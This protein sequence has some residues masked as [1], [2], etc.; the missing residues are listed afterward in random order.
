L[1]DFNAE[2]FMKQDFFE[3]KQKMEV[4]FEIKETLVGNP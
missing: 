2:K 4:I 3:M 1:I